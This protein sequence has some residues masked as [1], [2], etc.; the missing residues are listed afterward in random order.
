MPLA[1]S[2]KRPTLSPEEQVAKLQKRSREISFKSKFGKIQATLKANMHLTDT[3]MNHLEQVLGRSIDDGAP[4]GAAPSPSPA[5]P[6]IK[7]ET[8]RSKGGGSAS[9]GASRVA[10]EVK[11]HDDSVQEAATTRSSAASDKEGS[12][13]G[14]ESHEDES[15]SWCYT[16][17]TSYSIVLLS[18]VLTHLEPSCLSH[19]ALKAVVRRGARKESQESLMRI[20]EFTTGL[21]PNWSATGAYKR[22]KVLY[23]FFTSV[24]LARGRRAKE[25]VLPVRWETFGVYSLRTSGKKIYLAQRWVN[26]EVEIPT[27]IVKMLGGGIVDIRIEANWS[28][29]QAFLS[30]PKGPNTHLCMLLLPNQIAD[31]KVLDDFHAKYLKNEKSQAND[32]DGD[33]DGEDICP[34]ASTVVKMLEEAG[35]DNAK[36]EEEAEE[37]D[38]TDEGETK[39]APVGLLKSEADAPG[40]TKKEYDE[41]MEQPPPP[42]EESDE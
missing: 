21:A 11:V 1:A 25:M 9:S 2:R 37:R 41:Y 16:K 5:K 39:V 28:E 15:Q 17:L 6:S 19:H 42:K 32:S 13:S 24:H 4:A 18:S 20:L 12:D 31:Q 26:D 7:Q 34:P 22:N 29:T 23:E 8:P 30:S 27:K 33:H 10:S 38:A 14:G 40:E 3:V 36:S 35:L